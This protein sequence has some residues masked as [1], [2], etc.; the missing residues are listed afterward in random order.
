MGIERKLSITAWRIRRLLRF[1]K[2]LFMTDSYCSILAQPYTSVKGGE[3]GFAVAF[4]P[5]RFVRVECCALGLFLFLWKAE[6]SNQFSLIKQKRFVRRQ[7]AFGWK[8]GCGDRI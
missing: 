7:S 5:S 2:F 8:T 4:W 1:E 3:H 6:D